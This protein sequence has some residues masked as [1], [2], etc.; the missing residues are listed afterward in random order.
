ML[1]FISK[2]RRQKWKASI[3][4][5]LQPVTNRLNVEKAHQGRKVENVSKG[6]KKLTDATCFKG[7]L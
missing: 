3:T 2:A 1:R 4:I 7:G 6:R 5:E